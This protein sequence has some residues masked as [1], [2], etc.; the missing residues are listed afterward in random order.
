M[1]K[2]IAL[3]NQRY[4][5]EVNGGSELYCKLYAERL[6][7]WYDVEV[8]TTCALDYTT[9]ENSYPEGVSELNGVTVRRFP[10]SKKRNKKRFDRLSEKVLNMPVSGE[11]EEKW[12]DE[13]G[14]YCPACVEYIKEHH[15]DYHVV[16]FMTYLYYITAHGVAADMDNAVLLPTAHDEKPIYLKYYR[17]VFERAK[18]II[19]NTVEEKTLVDSMFS[20]ENTPWIITG[21]G[22]DAPDEEQLFSAK[23]KYGLEDYILYVGRIDESK[24]C[25]TLFRYFEEYK[26]RNGGDLKLV[27]VGK[28]VMDIPKRDDIVY[29]G[30]VTDE[31]KFSLTKDARLMVLA[32][33][34]ESLS[35]IVIESMFYGRPVLLNG[36]C[37]VLKGH[38]T[39]SNAGLYFENFFEFEGALN[40]L[41]NN[42][43][44]YAIMR[45]NAKKYVAENYRWDAIMSKLRDFIDNFKA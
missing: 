26:K 40:Y 23:E 20:V 18:G 32:S 15:K 42:P 14:P 6:T 37:K 45:E 16:I 25:G 4:G 8:I 1:R 11:E 21:I 29:L 36:K 5:A 13:Q 28:T 30:F 38:C 43:D 2:K 3:V 33:E 35:M 27:L 10:V 24:G 41:L 44:K 39:R 31:E 19:Y 22:I 12:I 34:F 7:E 9:W 17:R